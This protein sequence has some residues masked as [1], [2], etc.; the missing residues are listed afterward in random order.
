MTEVCH[1][2]RRVIHFLW[3]AGLLSLRQT[4][5]LNISITNHFVLISLTAA[6]ILGERTAHVT[7]QTTQTHVNLVSFLLM[8][9]Q[10]M[11][12]HLHPMLRP[13]VHRSRG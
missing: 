8:S 1:L 13:T 2:P 7:R 12:G 11:A 5:Q 10:I 6:V 4:L 9:E 3:L